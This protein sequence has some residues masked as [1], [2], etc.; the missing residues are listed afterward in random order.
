MLTPA[1]VESWFQQ[2]YRGPRQILLP[3]GM[4]IR[5]KPLSGNGC[6]YRAIF[7]LLVQT[8]RALNA[9]R[10]ETRVFGSHA[11]SLILAMR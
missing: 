6:A 10:G 11:A 2:D 7:D 3:S 4:P 8:W 5:C 9:R 1:F